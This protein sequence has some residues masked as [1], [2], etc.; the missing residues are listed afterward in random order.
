MKIRQVNVERYS[1]FFSIILTW[2]LRDYRQV[3]TRN[4]ELDF[5]L[6]SPP[7]FFPRQF[8]KLTH[9]G[10][11]PLRPTT[12]NLSNLKLSDSNT[13]PSRG[14]AKFEISLRGCLHFFPLQTGGREECTET[15]FLLLLFFPRFIRPPRTIN[16][17]HLECKCIPPPFSSIVF[18]PFQPREQSL[19]LFFSPLS[20]AIQRASFLLSLSL[21][22]RNKWIRLHEYFCSFT[23]YYSQQQCNALIERRFGATSMFDYRSRITEL[24]FCCSPLSYILETSITIIISSWTFYRAIYYDRYRRITSLIIILR[25]GI[26]L[27][28][29]F[30]HPR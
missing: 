4:E 2:F 27:V 15:T 13:F 17:F 6:F 8:C 26:R 1:K 29:S 22:P 21:S 10:K 19:S 16:E 12:K 24:H 20:V 11:L 7:S 9:N 3:E 28:A 25:T 23:E 30:L 14:C 5:S 18:A